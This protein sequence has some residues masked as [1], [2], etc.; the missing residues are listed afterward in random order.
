MRRILSF[1][2]LLLSLS[3]GGQG[4]LRT[5]SN[6]VSSTTPS[7]LLTGL[8][9]YWKL[10][11]ASGTLYD[12]VNDND[13]TATDATLNQTGIINKCILIDTTGK[14]ISCGTDTT[15]RITTANLSISAWVK[16]PGLT[17]AH[18]RVVDKEGSYAMYV[19]WTTGYLAFYNTNIDQ[20]FD[21]D[22]VDLIDNSWHHIVVTYDHTNLIGYVDGVARETIAHS[23]DLPDNAEVPLTIGN[24]IAGDRPFIGNIDEVGLWNKTLSQDEINELYNLGAGKSYPF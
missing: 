22:P 10:D 6:Y 4:I 18:T 13:G 7:T 17:E 9:S 1:L 23:S 12:S 5:N 11:E 16:S 15:L 20:Q 14:Y 19:N 2:L 8:V 24:R 3:A 21:G